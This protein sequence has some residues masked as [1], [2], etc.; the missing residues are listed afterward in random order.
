MIDI[1]FILPLLFLFICII[2]IIRML[3]ELFDDIM[4]GDI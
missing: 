1:I 3:Y 2:E 4:N